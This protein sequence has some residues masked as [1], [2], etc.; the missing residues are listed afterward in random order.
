MTTII[1]ERPQ[2][3]ESGLAIGDDEVTREFT[4]WALTSLNFRVETE[5]DRIYKLFAPEDH[6]EL[7][8]GAQWVRFS[9]RSSAGRSP[10]GNGF[11][12]DVTPASRLFHYVVSRLNSLGKATHSA[13]AHQPVSVHEISSQLFSVYTVDGGNVHLAGCTL[14]DRPMLRLTYRTATSGEGKLARLQHVLFYEDGNAVDGETLHALDISELVPCIR[15][16]RDLN[17][18]EIDHWLETCQRQAVEMFRDVSSEFIAATVV[19]C[20]YAEGKLSFVIGEQTVEIPFAG[21][22]HLLMDQRV[23]P[24]PYTCPWTGRQSYHLAAT[25]DGRISVAEAIEACAVSGVRV[26]ENEL[27]TCQATG[28]RA[29]PEH[30]MDCPVSGQRVI[31]SSLVVCSM[32]GQGVS[33]SSLR[34][35]CCSACQSLKSVP[36][37]EPPVFSLLNRYPKLKRWGHWKASETS[38]VCILTASRILRQLVMVVDKKSLETRYL[39]VKNRFSTAWNAVPKS[40][41]GQY[42][43]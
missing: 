33:S 15:R 13:P 34:M 27:E 1:Q 41:R 36:Q 39:A 17:E 29:L 7:L 10:P 21:W 32:C 20:K 23:K 31:R 18:S 35:G 25:G 42:L 14:D 43:D 3:V 9:F 2:T 11:V 8:N 24:P 5:D 4:L 26:L 22:A 37:S 12:E 40:E 6:A 28:K 16:S 19:W 30:L 38:T